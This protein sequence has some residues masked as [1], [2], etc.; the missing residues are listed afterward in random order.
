M[1]KSYFY[2]P[3]VFGKAKGTKQGKPERDEPF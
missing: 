2:K 3:R 1:N